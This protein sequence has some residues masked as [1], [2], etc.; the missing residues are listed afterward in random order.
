MMP[1]IDEVSDL[2]KLR[3]AAKFAEALRIGISITR[4]QVSHHGQPSNRVKT[5]NLLAYLAG[6]AARALFW[7]VIFGVT[8]MPRAELPRSAS[9]SPLTGR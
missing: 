8:G 3:T 9:E 7:R 5:L 1:K 6:L 4:G 2:S